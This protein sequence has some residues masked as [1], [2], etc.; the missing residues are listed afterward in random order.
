MSAGDLF[1]RALRVAP[2]GVHSPVRA[3]KAVGGTPIFM[4]SAAG[5]HLT[6]VAGRRY[7]DFCLSFGPLILGHRDPDVAAAAR[8]AIDDGWSYG[9]CEPYSLALA[10]WIT[11]RVPWV[12][13]L[14]FVSSGTEA[15]MTALRI[16]RAATG[17]SKILKFEGCYHGHAD[18]L[19]VRAGSGLAGTTA[20]TSAGLP[21]G[22]LGH[23]VVAPLDD[24]RAFDE[25]VSRA[26][27]DLAAVIVE[28][29]PANYG[30]L[31]PRPEWLRHVA[32]RARA[33]GALL[34]LDEVITGFRSGLQGAAGLYGIP[35]DL[36]CYG[37]VIGGGFPVAAYGGRADLM[38]LVAPA[39]PVYQAGTLSANPVGMRAGLRTLECMVERDGWNALEAQAAGFCDRLSRRLSDLSPRMAVTRHASVFWIHHRQDTPGNEGLEPG[40][41]PGP[42]RRPDRIPAS[43]AA[44]YARFFHA[45][46]ERGVY[47]PPS[48]YEVCFL[49]MAH[50]RAVLDEAGEAL[51]AAAAVAT[52]AT[53]QAQQAPAGPPGSASANRSATADARTPAEAGRD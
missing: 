32:S 41:Q 47:L 2:G 22:V 24:E 40:S 48:P 25:V 7:V 11:A 30:L 36:L 38:D 31:P 18:G 53:E 6:D 33:A 12:E 28:P 9:T 17:R 35:P 51:A 20:A 45:A 42:L 4:A 50:D 52:A 23:T 44:W 29:V 5:A 15:V 26:G 27:R 21:D 10:E 34:I 3:F 46:L 1:A 16:A 39:G 13:R 43:L 19:L 37:K 14:R 8:A 49:S